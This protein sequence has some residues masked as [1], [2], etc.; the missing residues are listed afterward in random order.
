MEVKISIKFLWLQQLFKQF[1]IAKYFLL[2]KTTSW[3]FRKIMPFFAQFFSRQIAVPFYGKQIWSSKQKKNCNTSYYWLQYA[4]FLFSSFHICRKIH[5]IF[6][7]TTHKF[8]QQVV[9]CVH[10]KSDALVQEAIKLNEIRI[11]SN[12]KPNDYH[13]K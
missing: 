5:S 9:R 3:P 8:N 1:L 10:W 7:E 11:K 13:C 6:F 12:S 2:I 4:F